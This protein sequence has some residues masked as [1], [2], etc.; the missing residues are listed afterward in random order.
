MK[1]IVRIIT[2]LALTAPTVVSAASFSLIDEEV[3][4]TCLTEGN[5]NLCHFIA[6]L[7]HGSDLL[8][9]LS[10]ILSVLII[11][12]AG[13]WMITSYGDS[14]RYQTGKKMITAVVIGLLIVMI[15]WTL[16][17]TVLMSLYGGTLSDSYARITGQ[18]SWNICPEN[19]PSD[20]N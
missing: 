1:K 19:I 6:L 15:A 5:C 11:V 2:L 10:G 12:A 7:V 18:S 16:V 3:L 8:I 14:D 4:G 9:S 13:L 20:N 17:N